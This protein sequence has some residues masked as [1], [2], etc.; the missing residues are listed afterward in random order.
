MSQTTKKAMREKAEHAHKTRHVPKQATRRNGGR[1]SLG[2]S[3]LLI[4]A[5]LLNFTEQQLQTVLLKG[6]SHSHEEDAALG[7]S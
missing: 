4:S 2:L 5:Q 1:L 3:A 7:H 6:R